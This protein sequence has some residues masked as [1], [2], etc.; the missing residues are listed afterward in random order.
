MQGK[1]KKKKEE[2]KV[3]A[4]DLKPAKDAKGGGGGGTH[5]SS[6]TLGPGGQQTAGPTSNK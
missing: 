4:R 3:K 2:G 5:G 1:T 6:G